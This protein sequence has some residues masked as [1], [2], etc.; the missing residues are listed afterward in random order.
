M[1]ATR[2]KMAAIDYCFTS[3][4]A[5]GYLAA[6]PCRPVIMDLATDTPTDTW[7]AVWSGVTCSYVF[8]WVAG[9]EV[10]RDEF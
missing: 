6:L 7:V 5:S 4:S 9:K 2:D 1:N 10:I 3:T 8:V